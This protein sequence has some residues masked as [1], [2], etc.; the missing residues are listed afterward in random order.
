MLDCFL[1]LRVN[2]RVEICVFGI[3]QENV[4]I[5]LTY[6]V[7]S[8]IF[9]IELISTLYR[10][11]GKMHISVFDIIEIKSIWGGSRVPFF[12]EIA[13]KMYSVYNLSNSK[14]SNVKF[15]FGSVLPVLT[16]DENWVLNILLDHPSLI[17][18]VQ[19]EFLDLVD[20]VEYSDAAPTIWVL[21][22]FAYPNSIF[23]FVQLL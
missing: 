10:V 5:F 7:A 14:H 18:F 23:V 19:Q 13:S 4:Q 3:L 9:P 20:V 17:Y 15:A 22:R 1:H 12:E 6:F 16:S 2:V 8:F 21:T 11:I